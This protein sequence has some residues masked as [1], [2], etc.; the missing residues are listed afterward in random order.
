MKIKVQRLKSQIL[1][2]IKMLILF[3]I[4]IIILLI[5]APKFEIH[6]YIPRFDYI[7]KSVRKYLTLLWF[8][9]FFERFS[10]LNC[11]IS[12]G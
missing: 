7:P 5:L 2:I 10:Q 12:E 4:Y 8:L 6:M 11:I 9:N 1:Y 3:Q